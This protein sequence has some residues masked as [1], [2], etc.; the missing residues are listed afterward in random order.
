M[1]VQA[2]VNAKAS[3]QLIDEMVLVEGPTWLS[4]RSRSNKGSI[5]N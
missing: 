3:H 1:P 5:Y 2:F 4:G